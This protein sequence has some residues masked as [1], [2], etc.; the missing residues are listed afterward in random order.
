[1]TLLRL[2]GA[3][4]LLVL[5]KCNARVPKPE[6]EAENTHTKRSLG[7]LSSLLSTFSRGP[8]G[9]LSFERM[10]RPTQEERERNCQGDRARLQENFGPVRR[11]LFVAMETAGSESFQC[12]LW[13]T[14]SDIRMLTLTHTHS[15]RVPSGSVHA[16]VHKPLGWNHWIIHPS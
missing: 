11:F 2:S 7:F 1:M 6:R 3:Q 4:S 8:S 9:C 10:E 14:F 13:D 16:R 15:Q 5:T 12:G